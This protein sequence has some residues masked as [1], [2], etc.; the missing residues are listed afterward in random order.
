METRSEKQKIADEAQQRMDPL[1]NA[2]KEHL[3]Q[4]LMFQHFTGN[5]VKQL[6]EVSTLW[7]EILLESKKCGEKLQLTIRTD[8]D[9]EKLTS[10]KANGRKYATVILE[11]SEGDAEFNETPFAA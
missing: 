7:N 11:A 10:I 3:L 4:E 6:F 1:Q 9:Y 5:E 2:L 8:D